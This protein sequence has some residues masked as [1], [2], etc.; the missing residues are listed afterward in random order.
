MIYCIIQTFFCDYSMDQT[1]TKGKNVKGDLDAKR[2]KA[3]E[4][5]AKGRAKRLEMLKAKKQQPIKNVKLVDDVSDSDFSIYSDSDSSDGEP[6]AIVP[7]KKIKTKKQ[8]KSEP[9][10]QPDNQNNQMSQ[11]M[12]MMQMMLNKKTAKKPRKKSSQPIINNMIMPSAPATVPE[13]KQEKPKT[14][15][16]LLIEDVIKRL[17]LQ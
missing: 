11:M 17:N 9:E 14:R 16:D 15:E 7:M 3:M 8:P 10:R 2:L 6:M 13:P 12:E 4:N 5:L 1:K